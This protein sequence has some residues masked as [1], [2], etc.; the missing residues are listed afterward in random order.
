MSEDEDLNSE[1]AFALRAK[2]LLKEKNLQKQTII[3]EKIPE[4]T[5]AKHR[6]SLMQTNVD[7][8]TVS[9]MDA[10]NGAKNDESGSPNATDQSIIQLKHVK[11]SK[12]E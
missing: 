8:Q 11:L 3:L 4:K 12:D 6:E 7:S 2:T 5:S 9:K 1:S 10:T